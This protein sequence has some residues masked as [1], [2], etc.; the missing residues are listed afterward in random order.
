MVFYLFVYKFYILI[1]GDFENI[2]KHMGKNYLAIKPTTTRDIVIDIVIFF[3]GINLYSLETQ[4]FFPL[5]CV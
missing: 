1:V 4:F 5:S 3:C 2:M